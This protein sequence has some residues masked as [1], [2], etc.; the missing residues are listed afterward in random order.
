MFLQARPASQIQLRTPRGN[1][2]KIL[3]VDDDPT[4]RAIVAIRLKGLG[5]IEVTQAEDGDKAWALLKRNHYD[6]AIVDWQMPGKTGL[7]I[8]RE[9]RKAGNTI[10]LLMMTAESEKE[11]VLEA[12]HAGVTDYLI[13]PFDTQALLAKLGKFVEMPLATAPVLQA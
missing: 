7:E 4:C 2:M 9:I 3:V 10:P 5:G 13:K 1:L 12:I 6:G 11:R 8:V